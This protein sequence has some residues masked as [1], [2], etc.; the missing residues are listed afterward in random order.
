MLRDLLL[1]EHG[2]DLPIAG[3]SGRNAEDPVV[4]ATDSLFHAIEAQDSIAACLFGGPEHQWRLV[5]KEL[6]AARPWI[7]CCHYEIRF[8][9]GETL[10]AEPRQLHFDLRRLKLPSGRTTP[11]CGFALGERFGFGLPAQ[12]GWLHFVRM[13]PSPLEADGLQLDYAARQTRVE[14]TFYPAAGGQVSEAG[15]QAEMDRALAALQTEHPGLQ[16]ASENRDVNLRYASFDAGRQFSAL[17]L[18]SYR[19]HYCRVRMTLAESAIG[20]DFQCLMDS[21]SVMLSLF[22]P[23]R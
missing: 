17:A 14:L 13:A 5:G 16:P 10:V 23:K 2:L 8:I 11:A 4:I 6:D 3:G 1:K 19:G 12:F 20:Q 15:L 22:N 18:T 9:D 21:L 7:E